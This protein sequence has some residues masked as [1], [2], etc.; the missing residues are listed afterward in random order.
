MS[1][2]ILLLFTLRF[3]YGNSEGF[4]ANELPYLSKHFE[5]VL[6][7]PSDSEDANANASL[8]P[9]CS[10]D[11]RLIGLPK[12]FSFKTFYRFLPG[13]LKIWFISAKRQ[14]WKYTRY[15]KGAAHH[16][17]NDIRKHQKIREIALE[18]QKQDHSTLA[19]DYW[20]L[21]SSLSLIAC[22]KEGLLKH[23]ICRAH[24]FDLYKERHVG[25][26]LPFVE[27]KLKNL[28][29]VF[30][31]SNHGKAYLEREYNKNKPNSNIEVRYLGIENASDGNVPEIPK[32]KYPI[33]VSCSGIIPVKRVDTIAKAVMLCKNPLTWIHF[34]D[35]PLRMKIESLVLKASENQQIIL[36]G[37]CN[38]KEILQFYLSNKIAAFLSASESEGLPVSMMEAQAS[39]I[40]I[41]APDLN[42]I[43]EIVTPETGIL[44]DPG[45]G[46]GNLSK[47]I[48]MVLVEDTFSQARIQSHFQRHFSA[49]VNYNN[50]AIEIA[51]LAENA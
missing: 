15:I 46:A 41:I 11:S 49:E 45:T 20:M 26:F 12:T 25:H 21:N 1:D 51:D 18:C 7:I 3:P 34:G 10:I 37:Q 36:A 39:G 22:K 29:K 19:Y 48:D 6:I 40:P 50:F 44:Y 42:G 28:D 47:L 16:Y 23:V 13:F 24:G 17:F 32:A 2:K 43:P 35:G 27:Y 9:N 5:K 8:P 30:T 4:I 33:V 38:N 31:I 14:P